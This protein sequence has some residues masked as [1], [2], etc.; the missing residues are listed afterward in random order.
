LFATS[1][2]RLPATRQNLELGPR[3]APAC[4]QGRVSFSRAENICTVAADTLRR[5]DALTVIV[6]GFTRPGYQ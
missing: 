1:G 5:S 3:A 4:A 2:V 6:I